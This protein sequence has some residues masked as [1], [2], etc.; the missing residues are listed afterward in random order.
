MI[1]RGQ[2]RSAIQTRKIEILSKNAKVL[3]I[4]V[5]LRD[6]SLGQV[7]IALHL[8]PAELKEVLEMVHTR[9][10]RIGQLVLQLIEV[11]QGQHLHGR[12]PLVRRVHHHSLQQFEQQG[13]CLRKDG[14]PLF[15]LDGGELVVADVVFLIHGKYFDRKGSSQGLDDLQKMVDAGFPNEE[16]VSIQYLQYHAPC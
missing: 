7:L 5:P 9:D 11:L 13:V 10:V 3:P 4:T 6:Q 2:P 15:L 1:P 16:R 12:G 8:L 14:A